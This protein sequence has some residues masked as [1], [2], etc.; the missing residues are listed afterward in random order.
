[1]RTNLKL[2][3]VKRGLTQEEISDLIGCARATYSM[4]ETGKREGRRSFWNALQKA[5]NVADDEMWELMK[6]E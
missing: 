5:F 6:V 4:I 2:F 3:R 1:M